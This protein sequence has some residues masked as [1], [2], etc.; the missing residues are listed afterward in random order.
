MRR[1]IALM[2]AVLL[3]L[4][5]GQASAFHA[6]WQSRQNYQA[7]TL[8]GQ[9][10]GRAWSPT[11]GILSGEVYWNANMDGGNRITF[12]EAS[13]HRWNQ[14]AIDWMKA[15]SG[16]PS[17]TFHIFDW[18]GDN[19]TNWTSVAWAG[20]NLP[21][22]TFSQPLRWCGYNETRVNADKTKLVAGTGYVAQ[23]KYRDKAP[24]N[25]AKVVVDTYWNGDGNYHQHYCVSGANETSSNRGQ[26]GCP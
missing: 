9:A 25:R 26:N 22:A 15:N 18:D 16:T 20:T 5:C 1:C 6:P 21:G 14:Q 12:A 23:V 24:R 3:G 10:N 19:C 13:Y 11:A 2:L 8:W 17:I 7:D 4:W